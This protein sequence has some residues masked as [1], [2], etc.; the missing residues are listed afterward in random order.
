MVQGLYLGREQSSFLRILLR[1]ITEKA[2]SDW[3]KRV[4]VLLRLGVLGLV[5]AD[6]EAATLAIDTPDES[7]ALVERCL[8]GDCEAPARARVEYADAGSISKRFMMSVWGISLPSAGSIPGLL[9]M[10]GWMPLLLG[11]SER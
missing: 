7:E 10:F 2:D 1:V 4:F 3:T 11:V 6:K 8:S 9:D 5:G